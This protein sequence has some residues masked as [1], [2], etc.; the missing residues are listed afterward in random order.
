[1]EFPGTVAC[2]RLLLLVHHELPDLH[3]SLPLKADS[4]QLVCQRAHVN[5]LE[6]IEKES[7]PG[8]QRLELEALPVCRLC[9]VVQVSRAHGMP[10]KRV[11]SPECLGQDSLSMDVGRCLH[12]DPAH[13][14]L[15]HLGP[16]CLEDAALLRVMQAPICVQKLTIVF[17]RGVHASAP[18]T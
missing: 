3:Q 17:S 13:L 12:L 9:F 1:M 15:E 4:P 18:L 10:G 8:F 7:L 2:I 16:P 5:L 6:A 11:E 14:A